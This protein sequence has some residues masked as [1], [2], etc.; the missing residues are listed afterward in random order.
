MENKI[1]YNGETL[2]LMS[3][4][5]SLT[6]TRLKDCFVDNSSMLTFI[7]VN[8][9]IGKAIGKEASN[10]KKL[11]SMLN[12]KIKIVEFNSEAL[13]FI[14]NLVY[15][16]RPRNVIEKEG[17]IT[18]ESPDSKSRGLLIGRNAQSLRNSEAIAKKYFPDIKE[19]KVI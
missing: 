13:G 8:G 12:R 17:I 18:I 9:D 16:I 3:L 11:E 15:P 4:F 6:R 10:V 2:K 7:V 14:R 5:E 1:I 19:I